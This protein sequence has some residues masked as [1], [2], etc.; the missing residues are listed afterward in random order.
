MFM[1]Q[2]KMNNRAKS[3]MHHHLKI[4]RGTDNNKL[5]LTP[6]LKPNNKCFIKSTSK[7][8]KLR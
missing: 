5:N 8:H 4:K 7:Y 1:M 2:L 6:F 3:L